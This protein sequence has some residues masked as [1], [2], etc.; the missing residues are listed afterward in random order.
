MTK[1]CRARLGM[2]SLARHFFVNLPSRVFQPSCCV[3][4]LMSSLLSSLSSSLGSLRIDD[5][6]STK[7]LD[8]V[9]CPLPMLLR[10]LTGVALKST[11]S[12]TAIC[13]H[14]KTSTRAQL[15]KARLS[16]SWISGNFNCYLITVK[17]GFFTRLSFKEKK[18]V[19]YN[20]IGP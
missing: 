9:T 2:H 3:R 5:F 4:S 19:I 1:K 16:Q 17:G 8:F 20:I 15:F 14:L 18:F 13:R 6:R 11:T 10:E 12:V 7:Q